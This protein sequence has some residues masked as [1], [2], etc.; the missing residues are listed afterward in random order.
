MIMRPRNGC[1]LKNRAYLIDTGDGRTNYSYYLSKDENIHLI[2]THPHKDHV[3]GV[4]FLQGALSEKVREI[5]VPYY[6][7]EVALISKALQH[8]VGIGEIPYDSPALSNLRNYSVDQ[9]LLLHL[10]RSNRCKKCKITFAYD[11]MSLCDHARFL[12][13]PVIR[14]KSKPDDK[15]RIERIVPLLQKPFAS[16]FGLWLSAMLIDNQSFPDAPNINYDTLH[17]E[18][19]RD[20]QDIVGAK[21]RARFVL[22]FFDRN[23]QRLASFV[24]APSVSRLTSVVNSLHL[25]ANQASLILR[26]QTNESIYYSRDK[27][28]RHAFLFT[29]DADKSVFRRLIKQKKKMDCTY[30]IV[31]HHG[32]KYSMD[33]DIFNCMNPEYAIISHGNAKFGRSKDAHPNKEVVDLLQRENVKILTTN[34]IVKDGKTIPTYGRKDSYGLIEIRDP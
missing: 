18:S 32:S 7:D 5:I 28:K 12:N 1:R 22:K 30:L 9:Q 21:A 20:A 17:N 10:V 27:R 24:N 15:Q 2:L 34:A 6:H 29:G 4:Q 3:G 23:Y 13:P 31:P 26:Y 16:E 11:G 14:N 25:T 8:L 33:E 19:E